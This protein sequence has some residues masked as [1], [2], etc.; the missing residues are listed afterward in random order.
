MNNL[1][2]LR[3]NNE[4]VPPKVK[5]DSQH[6]DSWP[7]YKLTSEEENNNKGMKSLGSDN[8]GFKSNDTMDIK[9]KQYV[10]ESD[11][12]SL[13]FNKFEDSVPFLQL[14]TSFFNSLS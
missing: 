1:S 8:L 3:L 14:F 11:D 12:I 7:Y 10:T 13:F 5:K 9:D 2:S 4:V 6:L